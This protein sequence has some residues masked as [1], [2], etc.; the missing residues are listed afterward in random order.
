VSKITQP[1]TYKHCIIAP[2]AKKGGFDVFE[3]SGRWFHVSTQKQAKWWSSIYSR[4][5][6]EFNSHRPK[7][8]PTPVEDHTPKPKESKNAN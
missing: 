6:D 4:L 1:T 2:V 7:S 5:Q 8:T 3:Q